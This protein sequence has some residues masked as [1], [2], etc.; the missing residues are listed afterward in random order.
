MR[1]LF[2]FSTRNACV[3][4]TLGSSPGQLETRT[5]NNDAEHSYGRSNFCSIVRTQATERLISV[6]TLILG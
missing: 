6:S 5:D 2:W 1:L 3:G 4:W